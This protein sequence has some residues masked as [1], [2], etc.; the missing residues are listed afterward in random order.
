MK[1]M[2]GKGVGQVRGGRGGGR[3]DRCDNI[4]SHGDI[5]LIVIVIGGIGVVVVIVV[6]RVT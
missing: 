3:D 1:A 2:D 5:N 4:T 6:D